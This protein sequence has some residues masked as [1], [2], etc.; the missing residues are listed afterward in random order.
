MATYSPRPNR[1]QHAG[2]MRHQPRGRKPRDPWAR[3]M[4]RRR[5]RW[6]RLCR[7]DPVACDNAAWAAVDRD[8]TRGRQ[9]PGAIYAPFVPVPF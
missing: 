6:E 9:Q 1:G 8:A 3:K 2:P 5:K 4:H 7:R